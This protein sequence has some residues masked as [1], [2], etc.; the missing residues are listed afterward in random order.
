MQK[1]HFYLVPNRITVT[2]DMAGFTTEYRQVYQRTIKLYKGIDNTLEIE[3]RNSDQRR[4]DVATYSV[5]VQLFDAE[6]KVLV[7]TTGSPIL[8]SPGLMSVTIPASSIE[9]LDP[10]SLKFTAYLLDGTSKK[11][12]YSDSQ[13][14]LFGTVD[15][16]DGYN[17]K[18]RG[19]ISEVNVFNFEFDRMQFVSEIAEFGTEL[20]D[21]FKYA[22]GK[23]VNIHVFPMVGDEFTGNVIVEGCKNKSTAIGNQWSQITTIAIHQGYDGNHEHI[24]VGG[25]FRYLR[26]KYPRYKPGTEISAGHITKIA[27]RANY[28]EPDYI[29]DGGISNSVYGVE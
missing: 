28:N 2:T 21:D 3:V 20:N 16:L 25:E 26:F 27:I 12:L 11:I 8:S 24:S 15:I 5:I 29:L 1:I 17:E 7:T 18:F 19:T 4:Q 13:F 9:Y 22:D 14:G 23:A 6:H 10:Q